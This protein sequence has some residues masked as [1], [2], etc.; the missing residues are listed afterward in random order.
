M[1]ASVRVYLF[2]YL[3]DDFFGRVVV[4][5]SERT[6]DDLAAQLFAW[7]PDPGRERNEPSKVTNEA[8]EILDP[9]L[10]IREAGLGNGDIFTV[11]RTA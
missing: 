11:C 8:G 4:A 5:P 10:T 7:G 1:K 2:G 6:I 3:Q 9:A